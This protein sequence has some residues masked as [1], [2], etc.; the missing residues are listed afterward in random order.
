M[1][2]KI[3]FANVIVVFL[4]AGVFG[5]TITGQAKF[6][7]LAPAADFIGSIDNPIAYDTNYFASQNGLKWLHFG[8]LVSNGITLYGINCLVT[9]VNMN[10]I[11]SLTSYDFITA[12]TIFNKTVTLTKTNGSTTTS[13][14]NVLD[15]RFPTQEMGEGEGEVFSDLPGIAYYPS[16]LVGAVQFSVSENFRTVF[17]FRPGGGIYVPTKE[18]DWNWS[19]TVSFTNG[20]WMLTAS[21]AAITV[22]NQATTT[23]PTWTNVVT[24][25]PVYLTP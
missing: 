15:N 1:I 6:N 17:M 2:Q 11:D 7:V 20:D 19:G 10:G 9:N 13:V 25:F 8:G 14:Q 21:N 23:F 22:N 18:I 3:I 16:N 4:T 5:Q 24:S 12:Q